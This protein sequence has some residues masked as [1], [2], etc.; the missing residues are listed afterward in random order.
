MHP[1]A[2]ITLLFALLAAPGPRGEEQAPDVSGYR[3]WKISSLELDGVDR[4]LAGTMRKGLGLS[5]KG[6]TLYEQDL[7]RDESRIRLFLARRGYPYSVVTARFTPHKNKREVKLVLDVDPGPPVTVGSIDL[8]GLPRALIDDGTPDL[9]P[10]KRGSILT[11]DALETSRSLVLER[12][13]KAGH[14]RADVKASAAL[15][16]STNAAVTIDAVPGAVYYFERFSARGASDD[17]NGLALIVMRIDEGERYDPESVEDAR[18]NLSSL[19]LYRQIRL[20]LEN[21]APD[22]L[23]LSVDL[24]ERT[25]RTIELAGGYWTDNGFSGRVMWRHRNLFRRGRGASVEASY[26]QYRRRGEIAAWWP[27]LWGLRLTGTARVGYNDIN[28]DSYEKSAPGADISFSRHHTRRMA[29]TIGYTIEQASYTIKTTEAASFEDPKGPVGFFHY[30][31]V[32]DGT[33]DRI[34][35][36]RGT[37]SWVALEYGPPGGVSNSDYILTECSGT[38]HV[39]LTR[40]ITLATNLRLGAGKPLG[41]STMLLPDRRI[42]AGGA[43]SHRGFKRRRLGPLDENG[44]PLGGDIGMTG[45]VELRF[46]LVWKFD[47]AVF[48]DCGQVWRDRDAFTWDNIETAVGPALRLMTPVG[49]IRFDFGFRLTDFVPD[50]PP[51]VFHFAIGYPM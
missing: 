6:A 43:N 36:R 30:R 16:D 35:P 49:P 3:G 44:L 5:E 51:F 7:S 38:L 27:A 42:Y 20:S 31:L 18:D 19:S 28:E 4:D 46:P 41:P 2:F 26:S 9:L 33:D 12:L 34:D 40:R 17:L 45:F 11:D 23:L 1:A 8:R 29:S 39:P 25:H 21:S 13:R 47:G 48:V 37:Y 32:R 10:L 50:E 22:S 24:Q 14:A 15:I